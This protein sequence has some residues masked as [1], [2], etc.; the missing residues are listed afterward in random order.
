MSFAQITSG[1]ATANGINPNQ[2]ALIFDKLNGVV[3]SVD[4]AGNARALQ[5]AYQILQAAAALVTITTAQNL[6]SQALQKGF[7]NKK[8]R[9]LRIRGF[10]VFTTVQTS[11]TTTIALKLG[12]V[13][14][15]TITTPSITNAQAGAQ[16]QFDF[17]MSV[18]STGSAG[19]IE[20]HGEIGVQGGSAISA[21]VPRYQDQNTAVSSAVNLT[22]ALTMTVSI[23]ASAAMDSAQLRLASIEVLN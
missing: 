15:A 14:L 19:T 11:F 7:L 2:Q 5:T 13:T 18:A 22:A 16:L 4:Q 9:T 17:L 12:A 3:E 10:V 1:P 23:A 8:S 20:A 21:A 6:I